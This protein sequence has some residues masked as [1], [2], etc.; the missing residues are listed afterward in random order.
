MTHKARD[1]N[2]DLAFL[3]CLNT[4]MKERIASTD[5]NI[6]KS[7]HK[8]KPRSK[9]KPK[10]QREDDA[11]VMEDADMASGEP[12]A[13]RSQ[14]QQESERMERVASRLRTVRGTSQTTRLEA[15]TLVEGQKKK[16]KRT[17]EGQR[18]D[19]DDDDMDSLGLAVALGRGSKEE[20]DQ[21]RQKKVK[22]KA[23]HEG[24]GQTERTG[25]AKEQG[26]GRPKI[27]GTAKGAGQGSEGE[28]GRQQS[29][30]ERPGEGES[31]ST[32]V[33]SNNQRFILFVGTPNLLAPL[34]EG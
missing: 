2:D 29:E 25:K 21:P 12:K 16:R 10:H 5:S 17:S 33:K 8:P 15:G 4:G 30:D 7:P 11:A 14:G 3:P 13:H 1:W 23:G 31:G 26:K 20:E 32:T 19:G 28:E 24:Q 6:T 18:D 27:E 22:V 9:S 34:R